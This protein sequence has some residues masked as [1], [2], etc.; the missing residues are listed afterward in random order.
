MSMGRV[1]NKVAFITGAGQGIGEAIARKMCDEGAAVTIAETNA[2]TGAAVAQSLTD[3]GHRALFVQADITQEAQVAAAVA[4]TVETFGQL[5][6]LVNNAGK[7]FY[8]DATQM[9]EREWDEAMNVDVK[10][11]WLCCKHAIPHMVER[12]GGSI[13]NIASI[14]AR[15]TVPGIFPYAA[16]KSALVGMTRNL[17]LDWGVQNI[18]VNAVCPGAVRTHLIEEW[19]NLHDDPQAAEDAMLRVHALGRIGTPEEIA[20]FVTFI[21]SD[22]AS[23]ITGAELYIDGGLS[24][25]FAT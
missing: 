20:N 4:Q 7:N 22:E 10:G 24:A 9:T 15:M 11:A 5:D 23:F 2:Q 12:G 21:A 25:R 18:R 16:A 14:H 8:Y 6:I 19:F 13:V 1:A 17:A 3:A